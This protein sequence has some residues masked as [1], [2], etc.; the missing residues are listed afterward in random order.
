MSTPCGREP[1]E[2]GCKVKAVHAGMYGWPEPCGRCGRGGAAPAETPRPAEPNRDRAIPEPPVLAPSPSPSPEAAAEAWLDQV[3]EPAAAGDLDAYLRGMLAAEP[4]EPQARE[5]DCGQAGEMHAVSG[6]VGHGD[7]PAEGA[8]DVGLQPAM[9]GLRD[10][11]GADQPG[12]RLAPEA[13]A[14]AVEAEG[15]AP[16]PAPENPALAILA[17]VVADL[18]EKRLRRT[19]LRFL[20]SEFNAAS[21]ADLAVRSPEAMAGLRQADHRGAPGVILNAA[22]AIR[23]ARRGGSPNCWREVRP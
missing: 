17:T 3:A 19:S 5:N 20:Q 11:A 16:A 21:P 1:L 6:G 2:W 7:G 22:V 9:P 12:Q 23:K 18:C 15:V 4:C 10:L 14:E 13:L 8:G